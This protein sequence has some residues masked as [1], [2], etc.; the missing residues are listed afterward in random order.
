METDICWQCSPWTVETQRPLSTALRA[1]KGDQGWIFGLI[2]PIICTPYL[3]FHSRVRTEFVIVFIGNPFLRWGFLIWVLILLR[4][5][6][7]ILVVGKQQELPRWGQNSA[8]KLILISRSLISKIGFPIK[9]INKSIWYQ[10]FVC[11]L[12]WFPI[13]LFNISSSIFQEFISNTNN[14][15]A[16]K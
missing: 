14:L 13:L 5:F 4:T 11:P 16:T 2:N 10:S 7:L 15:H 9:T 6:V 8:I 1:P 3:V 12:L